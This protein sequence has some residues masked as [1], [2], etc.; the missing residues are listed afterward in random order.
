MGAR[1]ERSTGQ[2]L[3]HGSCGAF[4]ASLAAVSA[5]F[6]WTDINWLFVG[7][8]AAFGFLLAAFVGDEAIDFLKRVFW[9]W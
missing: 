4:L 2:I 1:P 6:W 8:C 7:I 9:W 3:V 5:H